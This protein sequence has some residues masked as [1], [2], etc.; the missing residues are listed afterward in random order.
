MKSSDRSIELAY[1]LI[2]PHSLYRS[3]TGG[4]ISRLIALSGLELVAARMFAPSRDL[5]EE[6]AEMLISDA[7][8][9]E[10]IIQEWIKQYVLENLAPGPDGRRRRVMM[11]VFSGVDAA[12]EL[13]KAVGCFALGHSA[14]QTVRDTY[15]E[16]VIDPE[17]NLRYF[18]P[19][20]LAAPNREEAEKHLKLWTRYSDRD[21][22]LLEGVIEYGQGVVPERTLVILKPENFRF[23]SGRPGNMI[24]YFSRTGLFIVGI[25]VLHMSPAQAMEFYGPVR[26]ILRERFKE[27]AAQ[28]AKQLLESMWGFEIPPD[29]VVKLGELLGPL[30][31][32]NQF[33]K[34]IEFMSGKRPSRCPPDELHKPGTAK[35][36]AIVYEGPDA[37]AKIRR[38]LGPTDPRQ[39]PPGSIRREFGTDVMVNAAHASDSVENAE[40]E[41]RIVNIQENHLRQ[42]VELVYGPIG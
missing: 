5:I 6:Y 41:I 11:L 28:S 38:V 42:V 30:M 18:E 15:G 36:L 31:G 9:Q 4:I 25:R 20:V 10:R 34:I 33:E 37:V 35:T 14:G 29:V 26:P 16:L 24:D 40:R 22:G 7:D 1:A 21:G 17:G 27:Y 23:P 32:D 39:A 3:R 13:Y 8:P 2:T 12:R 19:A